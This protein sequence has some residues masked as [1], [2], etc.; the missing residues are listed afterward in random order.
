MNN[1]QEVLELPANGSN[2]HLETKSLIKWASDLSGYWSRAF[3]LQ[4]RKLRP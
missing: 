4:K 2:N 1:K 3:I